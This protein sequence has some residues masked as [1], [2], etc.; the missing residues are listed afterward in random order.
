MKEVVL[1]ADQNSSIAPEDESDHSQR[2]KDD[3]AGVL[4]LSS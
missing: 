4:A 3:D 1:I 2:Q